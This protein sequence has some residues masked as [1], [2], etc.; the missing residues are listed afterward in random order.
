MITKKSIYALCASMCLLFL[1]AAC[2]G[3]DEIEMMSISLPMGYIP[4]PQF[5]PIYVALEKGYFAEEGFEVELDY[6]FET[7]G[8]ALVGS[9]QEPF[10]LVSGDVVLSAR[11]EEVPLVY[12]MEW[13]QQY[14][15]AVVS[16]ADA[17]I[18]TPDDLNGRVVGIP[19]L[20]GATYVGY[21][22]LLSANQIAPEG[23]NLEE[24][25]FNQIESLLTGQVEAALVYSNN[26]PVR[27]AAMGEDINVIAVSDYI[28]MVASGI[29]TNE[30]FAAEN[31]ERVSGFVRAFTRGLEDV[32][33]DP[34][35][36]FE[37]SGNYI[38]G[39]S[40]E[41]RGVLDASL[42]MWQADQ[43]GYSDPAA[44]TQTQDTLIGMGFLAEPLSD[45]DS[46]YTNR[47]LSE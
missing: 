9:G 23:V 34:N 47:F 3:S 42:V 33:A 18:A 30:T 31:P 10:A 1:L 24:I 25:G 12:V 11:A 6:S 15:I 2:G 28:D 21:S 14:P 17:D 5:A 39:L 16:R 35:E 32:L 36:A 22:G 45:L 8:V 13:W 20:F 44:W 26:E 7:D 19:G 38:E 37:I 4:D 43:L 40:D 46:V 29:V 27:L 41:Q